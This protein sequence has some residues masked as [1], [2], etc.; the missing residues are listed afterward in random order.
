MKRKVKL[1]L[2]FL[3][4]IFV[5]LQLFPAEKPI[6]TMDNPN[7]LVRSGLVSKEVATIIETS[8]YDCHSNQTN[9]PWYSKI[10]P[11]SWMLFDH[12]KEGREHL[13]F[14]H[15][16]TLKKEDKMEALDDIIEEVGEGEMP[17]EPYLIMHGEATLSKH[18]QEALI[19][20]AES[21]MEDLFS[22]GTF[23]SI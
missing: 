8:C 13:N 21:Y 23:R 14:S 10:A 22:S 17:L 5:L 6:V 19:Q 15:W 2:L 16:N 20:W 12:I 9:Y 11:V 1:L 18:Q 4:G 3:L 7:D